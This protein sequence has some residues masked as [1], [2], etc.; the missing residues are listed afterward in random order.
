M[1]QH[2]KWEPY[3]LQCG[4]QIDGKFT[5]TPFNFSTIETFYTEQEAEELKQQIK[6]V[7]GDRTT[8]TVVEVLSC[9]NEIVRKYGEF[10]FAKDYSLYT[11]KQWGISPDKIDPS[12]LKRVPLRFS[13]DEG[14]FDDKYQVMPVHSYCDFFHNL[15]SHENIE[16]KLGIDVLEHLFVSTDGKKSCWMVKF[17]HIRLSIPV[18]WTNFLAW[19]KGR[20]PIVL[21]N[22]NGIMRI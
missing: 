8:A 14:Y 1:L 11:A 18:R 7:F 20:C 19:M 6:S 15:L 2:E 17:L 16:V 12:V 22:L 13:Y 5:P 3:A 10:L 9:A 4:A 21:S